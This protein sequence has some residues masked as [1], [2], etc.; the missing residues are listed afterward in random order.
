MRDSTI[1]RVVWGVACVAVL[2]VMAAAQPPAGP[3]DPAAS[4]LREKVVEAY[5]NTQTYRATVRSSARVVE[6][7]RERV[8]TTVVHVAMDRAGRKMLLD[9]PEMRVVRDGDTLRVGLAQWPGQHLEMAAPEDMDFTSLNQAM[10]QLLDQ[11]IF[12]PDLTLLLSG[13]WDGRFNAGSVR[14]VEPGV[15]DD[16]TGPGLRFRTAFGNMTFWLDPQ[17]HQVRQAVLDADSSQFNPRANQNS[18]MTMTYEI[19]ISDPDQALAEDTFAFDTENSQACGSLQELQQAIQASMRGSMRHAL[20]GKDAPP[21]ELK[22]IEDEAFKLDEVEAEVVVLDFWATWC[23]PCR[24]GLPQLQAF[25]DWA[26]DGGKPVAV[27]AVNL[28]ETPE[29]VET[30]WEEMGLSLPVLMDQDGQVAGAYQVQGIPQTVVI[31]Q[32]RVAHVHVGNNPQMLQTLQEQ[33][34]PLLS[35]DDPSHD[36]EEPSIDS[37][38]SGAT[39]QP[40]P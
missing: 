36:E 33:V 22:T 10:P 20:E 40:S 17:S 15:D 30:F 39:T 31:H 13:D 32:G 6:P 11:S 23:G 27:Y 38:D 19:Q 16:D 3:E 1:W 2:S 26:K 25:A 7:R 37:G 21:I 35:S 8:E 9:I 24:E 4:A 34:E 14:L 5:A 29:Q 28:Q 18:T 12:P